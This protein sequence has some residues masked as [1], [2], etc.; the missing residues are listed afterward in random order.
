MALKVCNKYLP[1][2]RLALVSLESLLI[3]GTLWLAGYLRY[4]NDGTPLAAEAL[5]LKSILIV[6]AVQLSLY[7]FDLYDLRVF[8][9]SLEL[10]IR[11][12]QALGVSS[13]GLA[14]LYYFFPGLIIGR[15]I[16]ILSLGFMGG[17]IV[18]W[19]ML[20]NRMLKA[21]GLD[22]KILILG[23]GA[24]SDCITR[25]IAEQADTG[26][27][28]I[29]LIAASPDGRGAPIVGTAAQ[30]AEVARREKVH[31]I[32]VALEERRGRFPGEQ[33]MACKLGGIAVEEGVDF[34]ER[35]T[36]RLQV[37]S[38]RPSSLIFS[39]GFRQSRMRWQKRGIDFFMSLLGMIFFSPWMVLLPLL[40]K[41]DSRGPVFYRQERVG[42]GARLFHLLKFRSMLPDA[43]K[44]GPLWAGLE[45]PRIT[46]LGR[47][48]RKWR[49]D[50]IPQLI[51]VLKGDMSFVGPR[52]ERP[53]FV[54]QLR[55]EIPFYS[56][57]HSIKP[58]ITG[59]AQIRYPYGASREDALQKLKYDLY[60]I[61]N[62]SLWLDL[63]IIFETVKV[64]LFGKGSR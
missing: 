64:V 37:E 12:L 28:V 6:A 17:V 5:W 13:V 29:G 24:L 8:R 49:L 21:R 59:W 55:N 53:F 32:I 60:Y 50:E 54:E 22:E 20:Y 30:L 61:K 27:K 15:G 34:Y 23:C 25:E 39:N 9:N 11:L 51:N 46:G 35:L 43:E 18:A 10:L 47:Y 36:G 38:L 44:N 7:Y 40:I 33:L 58:G 45:D 3:L 63:L 48:L 42:E 2:R 14:V 19:R 62:M 41:L 57:R 26:F 1:M 16:F 56:Q 4:R 31:R 52:P